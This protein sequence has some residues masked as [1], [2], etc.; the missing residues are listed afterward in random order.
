MLKEPDIPE[1]ELLKDP[2]DA[3]RFIA[4]MAKYPKRVWREMKVRHMMAMKVHI[5]VC[6]DCDKITLD[7]SGKAPRPK[8]F[9]GQEN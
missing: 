1:T 7:M 6:R 5:K 9:A 3:H 4:Y 2:F 8:P